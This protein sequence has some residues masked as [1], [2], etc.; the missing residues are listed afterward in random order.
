MDT[1]VKNLS[2]EEKLTIKIHSQ[3]TS[4]NFYN[5]L[6]FWEMMKFQRRVSKCE[7]DL[8]INQSNKIVLKGMD[9]SF[10]MLRGIVITNPDWTDRKQFTL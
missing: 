9:L 4:V 2:G 1:F 3:I 5:I 10:G 6:I 7:D 8:L